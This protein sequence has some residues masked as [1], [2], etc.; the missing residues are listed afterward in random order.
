MYSINSFCLSSFDLTLSWCC[1]L[2]VS[3]RPS[4]SFLFLRDSCG[5]ECV[6]KV[7]GT[8]CRV[9]LP[10]PS[11]SLL[12]LF[13]PR[14]SETVLVTAIVGRQCNGNGAI[15]SSSARTVASTPPVC[16]S[17]KPSDFSTAVAGDSDLSSSISQ[18]LLSS[19][20]HFRY[21]YLLLLLSSL[22]PSL[23]L[24]SSFAI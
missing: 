11:W 24:A 15:R 3:P 7:E 9:F 17:F 18:P 23:S 12:D 21:C 22:L 1:G 2:C 10:H 4:P 6:V 20:L 5:A 8:R 14:R 13:C 19:S 16:C